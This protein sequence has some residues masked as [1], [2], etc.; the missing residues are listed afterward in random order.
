M[1]Q[2]ALTYTTFN[3]VLAAVLGFAGTV[4]YLL[5]LPYSLQ[6]IETIYGTLVPAVGIRPTT[7][8]LRQMS[9]SILFTILFILT[10]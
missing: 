2:R 9:V 8:G 5:F 7:I 3:V 10:W 6:W 4:S 1:G